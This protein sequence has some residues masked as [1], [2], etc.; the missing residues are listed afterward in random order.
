M[1]LLTF[2][3]FKFW[4]EKKN[5]IISTPTA[6][7]A[8]S[9]KIFFSKATRSFSRMAAFDPKGM[10]FS[11]LGGSGLKVSK[12]S[13]GGWLTLGGT[14]QGDPVKE[15][16]KT[17]FDNGINTW[18][19][20]ASEESIDSSWLSFRIE[21]IE[22]WIRFFF[23]F[24]SI[25]DFS[26]DTAE[27]YANGNSEIEMGRVIQEMGWN[28]RELVIITKVFFGTGRADPNQRG[29]SSSLFHVVRTYTNLGI[30]ESTFRPNRWQNSSGLSRKHIIEGVE[31]SLVRLQMSY[32]DVVL[33]HRP[34]VA[35]PMEETVRA[36]NYL[37]EKGMCFYWGTSEWTASQIEEA[38]G[39][40]DRLNLIRPM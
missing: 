8:N 15:L 27:I 18:V 2:W 38:I 5:E 11:N 34:D 6:S 22:F 26:F 32:V 30:H 24:V 20:Q 35:T 13:Y 19:I 25:T 7:F 21:L 4:V 28:R 36:F 16:M 17:C 14:V 1:E 33:A 10:V 29:E 39:I 31:D 12:F 9:F 23:A 37:I 3:D 40:A